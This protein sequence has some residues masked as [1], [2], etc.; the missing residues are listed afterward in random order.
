[1]PNKTNSF[2]EKEV[3]DIYLKNKKDDLERNILFKKEVKFK[4]KSIDLVE[5]PEYTSSYGLGHAIEFK[6]SDWRKGLQQAIMNKVLFPYSSLAIWEEYIH[7][8]NIVE[9]KAHGIGL[10]EVSSKA[11]KI[12]LKPKK[13][14]F[15]NESIYRKLKK[16]VV[17]SK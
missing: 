11:N 9:F 4:Q 12:I 13:S 8:I 10:V 14:D 7:R 16:H 6:I 17:K 2:S 3:V 15:L 5:I 1:M